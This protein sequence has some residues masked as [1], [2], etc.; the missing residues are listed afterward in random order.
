[1]RRRNGEECALMGFGIAYE[2]RYV[3]RREECIGEDARRRKAAVLV[4]EGTR[5]DEGQPRGAH[6]RLAID[7]E[8]SEICS[9]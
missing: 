3:V 7:S 8:Q 6:G 1:M 5:R 4:S 9:R 2:G